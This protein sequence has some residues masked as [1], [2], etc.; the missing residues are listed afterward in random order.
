MRVLGMHRGSI[1]ADPE[2]M[3]QGEKLAIDTFRGKEDEPKET[4]PAVLLLAGHV[5]YHSCKNSGV[6]HPLEC[7]NV[8]QCGPHYVVSN[9]H[10][11]RGNIAPGVFDMIPPCNARKECAESGCVFSPKYIPE[12]AFTADDAM[13]SHY[14][15]SPIAA[16]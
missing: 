2:L 13:E 14:R 12:M 1:A 10:N 5:L 4:D 8:D 7:D 15:P 16:G 9:Q 6:W 3:A 11:E